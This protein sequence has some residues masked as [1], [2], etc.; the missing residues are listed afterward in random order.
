LASLL[1]HLLSSL[2]ALLSSLLSLHWIL[3][4]LQLSILEGIYLSE[5]WQSSV[6][7]SEE[8]EE[9]EEVGEDDVGRWTSGEGRGEP[10]LL[11][12]LTF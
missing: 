6:E 11:R 2:S 3:L 9:D 5:L 12:S 8:E 7:L 4:S 1:A 10:L